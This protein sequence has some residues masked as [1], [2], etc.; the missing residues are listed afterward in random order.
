MAGCK[1]AHCG[2]KNFMKINLPP[3]LRK[4]ENPGTLFA[5]AP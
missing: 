1:N 5:V 3:C 2:G 4:E